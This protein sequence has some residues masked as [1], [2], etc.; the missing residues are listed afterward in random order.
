MATNGEWKVLVD[1]LYCVAWQFHATAT[2]MANEF[3]RSFGPDVG[4]SLTPGAN[5]RLEVYLDGEKIFDRKEEADGKYPDLARVREL[6]Q[7]IKAK[8]DS[9][10]A[11]DWSWTR[12]PPKMNLQPFQLFQEGLKA[13]KHHAY[14]IAVRNASKRWGPG[15]EA[16]LL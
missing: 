1:I 6:K 9:L 12:S 14:Q 4:I 15:R 2:W 7:Q 10:V 8:L 16:F 11:A 3:F 5:G 13:S